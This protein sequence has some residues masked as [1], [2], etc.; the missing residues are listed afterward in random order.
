MCGDADSKLLWLVFFVSL[1]PYTLHITK[2]TQKSIDN[3]Y[4]V[5]IQRKK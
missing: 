3:D 2:Q 1:S 4:K 5:G